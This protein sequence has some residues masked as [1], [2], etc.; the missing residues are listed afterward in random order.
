VCEDWSGR[1]CEA[2]SEWEW[3][4]VD[5]FQV[6]VDGLYTF[7]FPFDDGKLRLELDHAQ[8]E[9]AQRYSVI[10]RHRSITTNHSTFHRDHAPFCTDVISHVSPYHRSQAR[11]RSLPG[12]TAE[13]PYSSRS[14][15]KG[16]GCLV[17]IPPLM[18]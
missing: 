15:L 6:R 2:V 14:F 13:D 7:D 8:R 17:E 1:E 16:G 9:S 5:V 12:V 18:A 11:P 3:R 4:V 10:P